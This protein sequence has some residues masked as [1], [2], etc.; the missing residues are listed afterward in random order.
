MLERFGRDV[1]R[2]VLDA[3]VEAR[4]LDAASVGS[5]HLLLAVADRCA[6]LQLFADPLQRISKDDVRAQLRHE[7][8]DALAQIG[9]SLDLLREGIDDDEWRAAQPD[10]QL[11][12]N[13]EAREVLELA[14]RSA[15]DLGQRRVSVQ[16][17]IIA[18]M[19]HEGSSQRVFAAV[20]GRPDLVE[21][22]LKS[23]LL[24]VR[25]AAIG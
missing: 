21:Q 7:Q 8:R 9:V 20:G 1:C 10:D 16:H 14:L 17:L 5:E 11:P 3:V 4:A 12:F 18:L 22:R 6:L 24:Q 15:L 23:E 19:C 13:R 25:A 2:A